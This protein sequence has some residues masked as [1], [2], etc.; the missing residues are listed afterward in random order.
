LQPALL[1]AR[2]DTDVLGYRGIA[3]RGCDRIRTPRLLAVLV[4]VSAQGG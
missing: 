1:E 3:G 2:H 4:G